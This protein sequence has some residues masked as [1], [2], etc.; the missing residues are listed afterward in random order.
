MKRLER[1]DITEHKSYTY[2]YTFDTPP[3][4]FKVY[5]RNSGNEYWNWWQFRA[6]FIN[7]GLW[8]LNSKWRKTWNWGALNG[9]GGGFCCIFVVLLRN[10]LLFFKWTHLFSGSWVHPNRASWYRDF[11]FWIRIRQKFFVGLRCLRHQGWRQQ[12]SSEWCQ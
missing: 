6:E 2:T 3:P 8:N 9:G 11:T 5:F 1:V 10:E 12:V 4:S 7:L